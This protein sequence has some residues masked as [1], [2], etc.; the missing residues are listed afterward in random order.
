MDDLIFIFI[1][2][3]AGTTIAIKSIDTTPRF[4]SKL[5][6]PKK[7]RKIKYNWNFEYFDPYQKH[8]PINDTFLPMRDL[9]GMT[10]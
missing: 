2:S 7:L 10:M 4:S 5:I 3:V 6:I 1:S 8:V 9:L